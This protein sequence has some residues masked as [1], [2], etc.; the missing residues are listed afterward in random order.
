MIGCGSDL[1]TEHPVHH[2]VVGLGRLE[3][4]GH[5]T[6]AMDG[7]E[8]QGG[9]GGVSGGV[10]FEVAGS[11]VV[12]LVLLPWRGHVP[13]HGCDPV[14]G[15]D[16]RNGSISVSR[17]VHHFVLVLAAKLLIDEL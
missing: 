12:D 3:L 10:Y 6:G 17:V 4:G 13:V 15:A 16:S 9:V 2:K 8:S 5:V 14:L 7:T 1:A 11:Q